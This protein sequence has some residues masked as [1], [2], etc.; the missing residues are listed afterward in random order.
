M[1]KVILVVVLIS[2]LIPMNIAQED[3]IGDYGCEYKNGKIYC[4]EPA[5]L[6]G[7]EGT[8]TD[9]IW[10]YST[11]E[12]LSCSGDDCIEYL[13]IGCF[14]LFKIDEIMEVEVEWV[15]AAPLTGEISRLYET[16][17]IEPEEYEAAINPYAINFAQCDVIGDEST[18]ICPY[19]NTYVYFDGAVLVSDLGVGFLIM[20]ILAEGE[21]AEFDF[22]SF[23]SDNI[24]YIALI[25]VIAIAAIQMSRP[26]KKTRKVT[27]KPI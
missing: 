12:E 16:E 26:K 8:I 6:L 24:I 13:D 17:I 19:N 25:V 7:V 11:E 3:E 4:P 15:H 1:K 18:I 9:D 5:F 20:E 10:C 23:F 14:T 22:T 21:G 27:R 2:I